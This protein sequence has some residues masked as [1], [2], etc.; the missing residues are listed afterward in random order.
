MAQRLPSEPPDT[1][2]RRRSRVRIEVGDPVRMDGRW[3]CTGKIL[4]GKYA[5]LP[6]LGVGDCPEDMEDEVPTAT[7]LLVSGVG[8]TPEEARKRVMTKIR[9]V[10]GTETTP[11]PG[12]AIREV[13]TIR[14]HGVC[15]RRETFISRLTRLFKRRAG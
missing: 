6:W 4:G 14:G 15:E 5:H 11:P 7:L 13:E 3:Y 9:T 10:W 1:L 2:I 8:D 12:P